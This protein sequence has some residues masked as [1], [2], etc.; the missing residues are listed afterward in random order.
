MAGMVRH[1]SDWEWFTLAKHNDGAL[2]KLL[3]TRESC[4]ARHGDFFLTSYA[5]MAKAQMHAHDEAEHVF[6]FLSG[7]GIF[8][9]DTKKHRVGT[10]TVVYVP[11][12]VPHGIFNT[13]FENLV[14]VVTTTPPEPLWHQN[15]H[16]S[17]PQPTVD[18]PDGEDR[19]DPA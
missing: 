10:G 19:S 17:F 6:Y 8:V 7:E 14:C 1:V 16:P 3:V 11:P 13:G 4:G 2:T 18:D 12:K 15:H 5:P 9:M